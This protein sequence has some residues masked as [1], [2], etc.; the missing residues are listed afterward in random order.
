MAQKRRFLDVWIIDSNTVYREVPFNVVTD[1][2]QQGRLLEDDRLRP[3]GTAEWF[4]VGGSPEFSPY[5][6]RSEPHRVEDQ[7]EAL[8]SVHVDFS[9]KKPR[10]EDDSDVDM[11]PLI[12]VSL[13]LLVFFML[14]ATVGAGAFIP[15]PAADSGYVT[16]DPQEAWIGINLEGEGAN[17]RVVYSY[18][19]GEK[20]LVGGLATQDQLLERFA[21]FLDDQPRPVKVSINS[22][23]DV[24]AGVVRDLM[25]ALEY[26]PFRGKIQQKFLG[27]NER[28]P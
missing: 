3:S 14:T 15:L 26:P 28:A 1:W 7:A 23:P 9:W 6:P 2:I 18:G 20:E 13:V 21:A 11:I 10:G 24:K 4:R 12:D 17:Q 25:G 27:V 5:L 16:D 22:R 19:Q 8:E